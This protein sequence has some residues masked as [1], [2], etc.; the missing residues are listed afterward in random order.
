MNKPI[1]TI[2]LISIL[3]LSCSKRCNIEELIRNDKID[4]CCYLKNRIKDCDKSIEYLKSEIQ[5]L[6]Y[7]FES[8]SFSFKNFKSD[9]LLTVNQ[10]SYLINPDCLVNRHLRE[11]EEIFVGKENMKEYLMQDKIY[12][13]FESKHGRNPVFKILYDGSPNYYTMLIYD[14]EMI[15][16]NAYFYKK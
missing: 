16:R 13:D 3:F 1:I 12:R 11:I 15:V 5:P 4:S 9:N 10:L 6:T 8:I 7:I 14:K 2:L